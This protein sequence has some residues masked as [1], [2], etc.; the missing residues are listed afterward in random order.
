MYYLKKIYQILIFLIAL[1][2]GISALFFDVVISTRLEI[3]TV[4]LVLPGLIFASFLAEVVHELGH[5][6]FGKLFGMKAEVL[7]IFCFR[8]VFAAKSFSLVKPDVFGRYS[9]SPIKSD[10]MA[11]R[12]AMTTLGGLLF[13][14]VYLIVT[15]VCLGNGGFFHYLLGYGAPASFYLFFHN[16]FPY[17]TET[18]K[19]D[20]R[21]LYGILRK[22]PDAEVT[23]RI[24]RIQAL[25][26]TKSPAQIEESLY[27]DLPVLPED[28]RGFLLIS[29]LRYLYYLDKGDLEGV[30][31]EDLRLQDLIPYLDE[32]DLDEVYN[33]LLYDC[34]KVDR[35]EE[36]AKALF[37]RQGE[38][39]LSQNTMTS[40]RI[41]AAYHQTFGDGCLIEP[42]LEKGLSRKEKER[43]KGIAKMEERLLREMQSSSR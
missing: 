25:L 33:L 14:L 22:E 34:C 27:F 19:T 28:D 37:E 23:I 41:L 18:G 39:L 15:C 1:T 6:L 4:L 31:K 8:Y 32:E 43:E 11:F 10:K 36:G 13:S 35:D 30:R 20:G 26:L 40:Y 17:T 42:C 2:I 7:Q 21:I 38:L 5:L 9:M 24:M 29:E 3:L 16:A 12:Y